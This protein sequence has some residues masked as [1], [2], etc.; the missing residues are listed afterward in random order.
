MSLLRTPRHIKDISKKKKQFSTYKVL[1]KQ[2]E[3]QELS[4]RYILLQIMFT[5]LQILFL[6][7]SLY[8]SISKA[9]VCG[10]LLKISHNL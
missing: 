6:M 2:S 1:W 3:V 9:T 5:K 4:E 8:T 7:N 10:K